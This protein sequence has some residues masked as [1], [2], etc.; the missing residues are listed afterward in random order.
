MIFMKTMTFLPM[1]TEAEYWENRYENGDTGWDLGE[2]SPPL[3]AYFDQIAEHE[4]GK[5][6]LIPGAGYGYEAVYLWK[7]GFIDVTMLDMSETA[8]AKAKK[9]HPNLPKAWFCIQDFFDHQESYDLII[10]QT[11]FC[12]LNP[13]LRHAYAKKMHDLL[14]PGGKL[15]GLFFDKNFGRTEPPYGGSRTEYQKLFETIFDIKIMEK[16]YNSIKARQGSELFFIFE[17]P[18]E[19]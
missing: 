6:I 19:N 16:C 2:V 11:F 3:K 7:K 18:A 10:E 1:K 12:A 17:K 5:K 15:I 9:E 8:F 14:K 4:S 13:D